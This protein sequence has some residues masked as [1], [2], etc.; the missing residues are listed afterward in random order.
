MND[1]AMKIDIE[2]CSNRLLSGLEKVEYLF[3]IISEKIQKQASQK[4]ECSIFHHDICTNLDIIDD[5]IHEAINIINELRERL[6][7]E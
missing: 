2:D 7:Y 5:Y 3:N 1:T 4:T 6:Q